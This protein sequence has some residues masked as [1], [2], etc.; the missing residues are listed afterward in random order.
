MVT[1]SFFGGEAFYHLNNVLEVFYN[2]DDTT[3][4]D[5][6]GYLIS[7]ISTLQ[8]SN[9]QEELARLQRSIFALQQHNLLSSR[10]FDSLPPAV[11]GNKKWEIGRE[12]CETKSYP[13]Y[14]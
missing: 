8:N 9:Y 11:C 6:I 14:Y 2:S 7:I 12:E 3:N 13:I 1:G 10:C 5:G 4:L